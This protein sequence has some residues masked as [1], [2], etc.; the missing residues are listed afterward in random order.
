MSYLDAC[1]AHDFDRMA[2]FYT[3]T[4]RVNDI[5]MDATEVTTQFVPLVSAF[6]DWH[7]EVRHLVVDGDYIA[8]HFEVTGS[9]RG[10]FQGIEATGRRV[11]I[12]QFTLYR[13]Q[14]GKF[15]EVWDFADMNEVMKQIRVGSPDECPASQARSPMR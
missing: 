8:L 2:S 9:H 7:W 12:S 13:V 15:S 10:T 1:N 6:P 3:S 11:A 5:P 14:S 4:I